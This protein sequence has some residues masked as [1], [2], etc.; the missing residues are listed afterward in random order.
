MDLPAGTVTIGAVS[1]RVHIGAP[2][3]AAPL[4]AL[5]RARDKMAGKRVALV[6][7]GGNIDR[8]KYCQVL[9]GS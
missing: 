3:G 5:L 2:D 6:L 7:S 4:A 8:E 1:T 9:N